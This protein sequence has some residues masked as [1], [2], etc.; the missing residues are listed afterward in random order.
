VSFS[1]RSGAFWL[2]RVNGTAG[3]F[4]DGAYVSTPALWKR[5]KQEPYL[6]QAAAAVALAKAARHFSDERSAAV[7]TQTILTLLLDTAADDLK[8]P[9]FRYPTAPFVNRLAAAGLLARAI[10]ELPA[11]QPDLLDQAELLCRFLHRQQRPDGSLASDNP[12]D[13][14][15]ADDGAD[16]N[17]AEALH[18]LLCSCRQ[19]PAPWKLDVA[20]KA[21]A[22][23]H[24]RW[25]A[26]KDLAV[27]PRFSA[28]YA[29][30][31]ALTKERAFADAVFEMNDWLCQLQYVQLSDPL[32]AQWQGGFRGYA[33]G[34]AQATPP[35]IGSAS[36]A[37]ALADACRTAR[38]A[39]DG[40]RHPRY[41][42]ALKG[43][44]GF[45]TSLQ[46]T[47]GNTRHFNDRYRDE[48]IGAFFASH[49]DGNLRLDYTHQT[50]NALLQYLAHEGAAAP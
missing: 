39:G 4:G 42:E 47:E 22:Y 29:E 6:S 31:Y 13:K 26:N 8:A 10:S 5:S 24:P 19:R 35:D 49:Q 48:I 17:A 18:G 50:V 41:V 21:F 1:A 30:A 37:E 11:P 34:K 20:R 14:A 40:L 25:R 15:T 44:L 28:A 9:Q 46:Y 45:V 33:N 12:A 2:L 16:G 27:V 43:C 23:Y 38:Q 36:C 3:R 7:A 32:T